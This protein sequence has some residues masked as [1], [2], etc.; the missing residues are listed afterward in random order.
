[1]SSLVLTLVGPA[2]TAV[3][4]LQAGGVIL[5]SLVLSGVAIWRILQRLPANGRGYLRASNRS[6]EGYVASTARVELVGL[7]GVAVTDLRPSGTALFGGERVDVVSE[8]AFVTAGTPVRVV[9]A[10]GYRHVV[11]VIE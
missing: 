2:P 9:R 8:G 5:T 6:E 1:V 4:L 10:E 11:R 7:D 3:Q